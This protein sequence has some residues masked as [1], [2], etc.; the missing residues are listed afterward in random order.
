MKDT[1]TVFTD[2]N[3][4]IVRVRSYGF[5]CNSLSTSWEIHLDGQFLA[6]ALTLKAAKQLIKTLH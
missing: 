3:Y 5:G 1:K 2:G 6:S 4:S